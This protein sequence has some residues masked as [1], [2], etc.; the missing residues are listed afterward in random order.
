MRKLIFVTA[1]LLASVTAGFAQDAG[2][3]EKSSDNVAIAQA[4]GIWS[5]WAC[6]GGKKEYPVDLDVQNRTAL[7]SPMTGCRP[8][9]DPRYIFQCREETEQ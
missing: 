8:S 1:V 2:S 3:T 7:M 6:F 5:L 9:A 4:C